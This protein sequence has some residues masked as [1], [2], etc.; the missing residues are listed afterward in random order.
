M[1]PDNSVYTIIILENYEPKVFHSLTLGGVMTVLDEEDLTN[2]DY[3]DC[4]MLAKNGKFV[5]IPDFNERFK[6]TAPANGYWTYV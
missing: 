5:C 3:G 4:W 6:W 1:L 2:D